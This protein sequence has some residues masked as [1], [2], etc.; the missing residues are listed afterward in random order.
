MHIY[1]I[2]WVGWI[3]GIIFP[4]TIW[5]NIRIVRLRKAYVRHPKDDSLKEKILSR[6]KWGMPIDPTT[7][8]IQIAVI[9]AVLMWFGFGFYVK[10]Q[11]PLSVDEN[12]IQMSQ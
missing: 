4:L 6:M 12:L 9:V 5:L 2:I 10:S 7:Q 11:T 3:I 1:F 8:G